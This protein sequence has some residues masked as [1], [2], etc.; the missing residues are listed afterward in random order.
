MKMI[1]LSL[2]CAFALSLL[3]CESV[4]QGGFSLK[5]NWT[6]GPPTQENLHITAYVEEGP[7]DAEERAKVLDSAG[8]VKYDP[9]KGADLQFTRVPIGPSRVFIVEIREFPNTTA[10]LL[11][12]GISKPVDLVVGKFV[13]VEVDIELRKTRERPQIPSSPRGPC[14]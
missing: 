5:F 14:R 10:P 1:R 13:V 6:D 11:Y 7:Y 4:G 12:Y 9:K 2:A 3:A 8:P